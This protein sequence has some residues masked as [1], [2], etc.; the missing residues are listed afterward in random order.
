MLTNSRKL[1]AKIVEQGYKLGTFAEAISMSQPTLRSKLLGKRDFKMGEIVTIC[2][3]LGIPTEE[4]VAY[5]FT[6][7]VP[8]LSRNDNT[9]T[10]AAR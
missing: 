8:K 6:P 1:K 5:F 2:D 3:K 7:D 10:E 9:H 4:I